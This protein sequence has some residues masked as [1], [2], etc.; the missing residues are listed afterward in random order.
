MKM[1]TNH[2]RKAL[3]ALFAMLMP[4]LARAH[5]FEQNGIYYNITSERYKTLEVTYKGSSYSNYSNEYS[6]SIT[7]PA[8]VT[9]NGAEYS[10]TSIGNF[11]F[12]YCSN[13]TSIFIPEGVERIGNQVFSYCSNLTSLAIPKSI[14]HIGI[15]TFEECSGISSITVA[16]G[17]PI[18]DSREECN[19]IIE[20]SS[21][22]LRVGC[23]T[24]IIPKSVTSIG[25]YA[26]LACRNLAA[27][28]IPGG[29]TSIGERAFSY[30]SSLESITIPEG[31][32][33]LHDFA[34]QYC[35][36]LKSIN[37]PKSLKE[38]GVAA[39]S[40]CD[41]LTNIII[42]E[43]VT[44]LGSYAFDYT[45]LNSIVIPE[46]VTQIAYAMFSNC[47]N[48][49]S[50][51]LPSSI[52]ILEEKA[53]EYCTNLTSLVCNAA[54]P[55]TIGGS[56]TFNGVDKSIPVY[57]PETSVEAYK[58]VGGWCEFRNIVP[59][60]KC[61]TPTIPSKPVLISARDGVLT[62]SGLAEGTEVTLYTTDGVMVAHQQS[63]AGEA[64]FTVDTNQVYLVHIGDKVVK[65][66]M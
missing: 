49:T 32:T 53:F 10:V 35:T 6:G 31:I 29:M 44:T 52:G 38:I 54:T 56:E 12:Y 30:C 4:L 3:L 28:T 25:D 55:P 57:V 59:L 5:D 65:I 46:G 64:K 48:L 60:E 15:R 42:P 58:S 63:C 47:T 34:F 43:G 23:S 51:T 62:L 45:G 11:A 19:A 39:I 7:I 26:F 27:I 40:H 8:T 16:T 14:T 61:A 24:T 2:A 13:L 22:T 20:T 50:V 18:F 1:N 41:N 21:N 33:I 66:G 36:S 9:Y 17:N 37:L